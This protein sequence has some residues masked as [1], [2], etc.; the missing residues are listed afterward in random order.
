MCEYEKLCKDSNVKSVIDKKRTIE[1]NRITL[2][3]NLYDITYIPIIQG[4]EING[5]L[6][7]LDNRTDHYNLIDEINKAKEKAEKSD[8]LKSAFLANMSHEIRTPLNAIV[9]FSDLISQADSFE[10]RMEY[11]NIINNNS[12]LLLRLINDIL[13]LSKIE[14]GLLEFKNNYFDINKVIDDLHSSFMLRKYDN[15]KLDR[16]SVV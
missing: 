2:G 1:S 15:V 6:I 12:E 4:K 9:G 13:D 16:K 3:K 14:A 11:S 10:D 8:K 5:I 7:K